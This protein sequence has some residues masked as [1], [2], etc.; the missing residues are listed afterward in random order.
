VNSCRK[1]ARGPRAL[2]RSTVADVALP[3]EP[4]VL[5]TPR[6]QLFGADF[7]E[8]ENSEIVDEVAATPTN[9]EQDF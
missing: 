3:D 6:C 7:F 2:R 4:G 5:P 1:P 9:P 8:R